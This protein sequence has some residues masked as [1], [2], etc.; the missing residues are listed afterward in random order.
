MT[1]IATYDLDEFLIQEREKGNNHPLMWDS[2]ANIVKTL[3]GEGETKILVKYNHFEAIYSK[4]GDRYI[5]E[6]E[7]A[8]SLLGYLN[9]STSQIPQPSITTHGIDPFGAHC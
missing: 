7:D 9:P 8:H 6:P 2:I 4:V 1:R 5:A 3:I